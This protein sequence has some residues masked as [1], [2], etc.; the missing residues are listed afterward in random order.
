MD[1]S[2]YE[3]CIALW[4]STEGMSISSADSREGIESYLE[5][6]EGFSYVAVQ[7]EE[8]AG[9]LLAGHD[10]RRGYLYHLAVKPKYRGQGIA[11]TL[12]QTCLECLRFAGIER[13]HI[14]VMG[15][16]DSGQA[17]WSNLGW[18]QRGDILVCS[19]DTYVNIAVGKG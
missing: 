15:S 8:V 13:V 11:K 10:G 6:N 16:N 3:Q 12:V 1:A 7:S 4:R 18:T 9:T 5:R 2:D 17:F 19:R 14:M